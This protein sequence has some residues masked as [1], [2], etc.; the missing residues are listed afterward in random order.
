M[1]TEVKTKF[2]LRGY[3]YDLVSNSLLRVNSMTRESTLAEKVIHDTTKRLFLILQHNPTLPPIKEWLEELWPILYKSS[4]T[5][6]IIDLPRVIGYRRPKNLLVLLVRS[7]LPDPDSLLGKKKKIPIPKCNRSRCKHCP[8]IDRTG[9]VVSTSTGRKYRSQTRVSC[10]SKN[11]IYML[12][13]NI[14]KLQ[15]VGQTKNKILTRVSQ[16]YYSI[17]KAMDTPVSRHFRSHQVVDSPVPLKI[18]IL[19][20]I[21]EGDNAQQLRDE[22][23]LKWMARLNTWV[24]KGLNIQD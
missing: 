8:K 19:S 21:K 2:S 23:E 10:G 14:C 15:Y 17:K 13:C 5:R 1:H 7:D 16:H 18:Y 22:W 11:G 24:P 3:P 20:L 4:G 6:S 9:S 12:Q